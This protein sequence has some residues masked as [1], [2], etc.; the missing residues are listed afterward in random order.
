MM[1]FDILV[2]LTQTPKQ[3]NQK[4][5]QMNL[6]PQIFKSSLK[7]QIVNSNANWSIFFL[8]FFFLFKTKET[9]PEFNSPLRMASNKTNKQQKENKNCL[10]DGFTVN[11]NR[12]RTVI[13]SGYQRKE[14]HFFTSKNLKLCKYHFIPH[15][16]N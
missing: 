2:H 16:G 10:F 11:I 4:E 15:I 7:L 3:L 13:S 8:F 12:P 5:K 6:P 9:A 14:F 1:N